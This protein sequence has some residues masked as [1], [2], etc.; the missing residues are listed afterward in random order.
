M[1]NPNILTKYMTQNSTKEMNESVSDVCSYLGMRCMRYVRE[2]KIRGGPCVLKDARFLWLLLEEKYGIR[3]QIF[4]FQ[5]DF[6][7]HKRKK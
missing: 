4:K 7:F 6:S 2:F 5:V 3:Y 1:Y